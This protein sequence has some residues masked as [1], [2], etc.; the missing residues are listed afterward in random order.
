MI[1]RTNYIK[2]D[3][4][5][6]GDCKSNIFKMSLLEYIWFTPETSGFVRKTNI[7]WVLLFLFCPWVTSFKYLWGTNPLELTL[8]EIL[9]IL[10]IVICTL[11]G[12]GWIFLIIFSYREMKDAHR[13]YEKHKDY[14]R[15]K[16]DY[17]KYHKMRIL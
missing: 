12:L 9:Q 4:G 1:D 2:D 6:I 3:D 7:W 11:T 15:Y 13:W 10:L 5:R 14:Q 8:S 17:V 16:D